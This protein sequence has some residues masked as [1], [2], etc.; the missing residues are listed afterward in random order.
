MSCP[1]PY[2]SSCPKGQMRTARP[3]RGVIHGTV[4]G[5]GFE[6]R[7]ASERGTRR[8]PGTADLFVATGPA[9][10]LGSHQFLRALSRVRHGTTALGADTDPRP[11]DPTID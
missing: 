3:V 11:S 2:I 8:R 9:E 1:G 6:G 5:T 10:R 7:K 4:P